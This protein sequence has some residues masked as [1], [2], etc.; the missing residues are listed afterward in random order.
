MKT[1]KSIFPKEADKAGSQQ[2]RRETFPVLE[3]SCAACAVSVES[4]LKSTP[5]VKDAAVNFA[6]QTAWVDY[7]AGQAKPGEDNID[8][9]RPPICS[10]GL[11]AFYQNSEGNQAKP[12][13]GVHLQRDRYTH[14]CGGVVPNKRFLTQSDDRRC[15]DGIEFR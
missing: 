3:M 10:E 7:D 6:N 9:I 2:Y 8:H 1:T 13:L 15:G 11:Q 14:C 5:G 4:M 12:F